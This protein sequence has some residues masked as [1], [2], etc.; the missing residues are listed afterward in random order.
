MPMVPHEIDDCQCLLLTGPVDRGWDNG[1]MVEEEFVRV[2][3]TGSITD[4][5]LA[6]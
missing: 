1:A 3:S 6:K 2:Y 4:G 5:Y